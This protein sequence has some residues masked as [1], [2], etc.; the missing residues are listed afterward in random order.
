MLLELVKTLV[1][2]G[3]RTF[4]M[5]YLL[6]CVKNIIEKIYIIKM[7]IDKTKNER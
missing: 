5:V 3:L 7:Y 2:I 4:G 1:K 6:S